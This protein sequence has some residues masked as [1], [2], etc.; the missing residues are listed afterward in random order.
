MSVNSGVVRVDQILATVVTLAVDGRPRFSRGFIHSV[1]SEAEL[2]VYLHEA[3][4]L[5]ALG[6]LKEWMID[7]HQV[8]ALIQHINIRAG[9]ALAHYHI[10]RWMQGKG[11]ALSPPAASGIL[12]EI[13][14]IPLWPRIDLA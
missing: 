3:A 6:V 7:A 4:L 2:L 5:H 12:G 13:S 11:C 14:A 10:G 8:R 1:P 9:S